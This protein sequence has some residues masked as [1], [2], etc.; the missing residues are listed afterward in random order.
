MRYDF[1]SYQIC[2]GGQNETRN[3]HNGALPR[4]GMMDLYVY[5]SG[6]RS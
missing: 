2:D 5:R 3:G 4:T 6:Y 1:Y